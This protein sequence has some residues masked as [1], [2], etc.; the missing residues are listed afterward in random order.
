M[1]A[2][3]PGTGSRTR[4][5]GF[6]YA[7][8]NQPSY[9]LWTELKGPEHDSTGREPLHGRERHS[10]GRPSR[11]PQTTH[12]YDTEALTEKHGA[13]PGA[14]V[15]PAGFEPAASALQRRRSTN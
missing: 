10:E 6:A 4:S 15:E 11:R 12:A 13:P 7:V 9:D 3:G 1:S 8:A 14:G 5:K 2:S